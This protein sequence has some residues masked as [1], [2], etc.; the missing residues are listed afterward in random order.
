MELLTKLREEKFVKD[1]FNDGGEIFLVGGIVRDI[2]LNK[3]S[4]DIDLLIRKLPI[5]KII[6]IL[7]PHGECIETVVA[8]KTGVVKFKPF[9][10]EIGGLK[11]TEAIDIALPRTEELMSANEVEKM[12]ISDMHNAFNI[13]A[14]KDLPVEKDLERRDFTINSIAIDVMRGE[15][16]DPFN[17]IDDLT[18]K[19]IKETN[20]DA[21]IDDP[22]R[23]FRAI[24]FASR[25][26]DFKIDNDTFVKIQ[27]HK[28]R[29]LTLS[30]ERIFSEIMKIWD[31][32][33]VKKGLTLLRDSGLLETLTSRRISC[34]DTTI[35]TKE[36]FLF[37]LFHDEFTFNEICV[38]D[39]DL[40]NGIKAI[41][42]INQIFKTNDIRKNGDWNMPIIRK[43][44]FN[45][46]QISDCILKSG[47][48][49]GVLNLVRDEFNSGKFPKTKKELDITGKDLIDLGFKQGIELGNKLDDCLNMVL[50]EKVENKKS[51]IIKMII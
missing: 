41:R 42:L 32:G 6:Q 43:A 14:D 27:E 4:V 50:A 5:E 7:K 10:D 9:K 15:I 49:F 21:F 13:N 17:G 34:S 35:K 48:L 38:K 23:M 28:E 19:V 26:N 12:G 37:T 45:T 40:T 31:K 39:K 24:Q 47:K 2:F 46:L 20:P 29:A 44:F 8:G 33:S 51:E 3:K 25:F 18:N 16:I 22:L 36:D 30:G 11:I 1:L